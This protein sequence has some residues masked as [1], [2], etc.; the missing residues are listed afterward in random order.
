MQRTQ[1][2]VQI[3]TNPP[4]T[5]LSTC[6]PFVLPTVLGC[7]SEYSEAVDEFCL[8]RF[9]LDMDQLDPNQWCSWEDTM[10]PYL[11][12]TNCSYLVALRLGCFWP[13]RDVDRFSWTCTGNHRALHPG[14]VL[15]TLLM[16]ALVVWRSKRSEGIV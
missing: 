2:R 8:S 6:S 13:N 5:D 14:P 7:S 3:K 10:E 9:S 16:T 11:E 12:L 15:V 1:S 4:H